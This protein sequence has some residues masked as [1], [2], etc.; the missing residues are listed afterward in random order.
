MTF[1]IRKLLVCVPYSINLI[2]RWIQY[3]RCLP[4]KEALEF[5]CSCYLLSLHCMAPLL[6]VD[7]PPRSIPHFSIPCRVETPFF[8]TSQYKEALWTSYCFLKINRGRRKSFAIIRLLLMPLLFLKCR[9]IS[10]GISHNF[11]KPVSLM[12]IIIAHLKAWDYR[13][14]YWNLADTDQLPEFWTNLGFSRSDLTWF[15][16]VL[17][18]WVAYR[19][20]LCQKDLI[21]H[22]SS[23]LFCCRTENCFGVQGGAHW[24]E[25]IGKQTFSFLTVLA[26]VHRRSLVFIT[27]WVIWSEQMPITFS[28]H[29]ILDFLNILLGL[30]QWYL[31]EFRIKICIILCWRRSQSQTLFKPIISRGLLFI[32][33]SILEQFTLTSSTRINHFSRGLHSGCFSVN[34]HSCF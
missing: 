24:P 16:A 7:F 1:W 31:L 9:D 11:P 6:K 30:H 21:N 34:L 19:P 2:I 4:P 26:Y 32:N 22:F 33:I 3:S 23:F 8:R 29:V 27:I 20:Q 18:V 12:G 25:S 5:L 17:V 15:G 13:Y 14:A 10:W 28:S